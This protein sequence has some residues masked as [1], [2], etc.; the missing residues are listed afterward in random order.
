MISQPGKQLLPNISSRQNCKNHIILKL[1]PN[2][3]LTKHWN[4]KQEI[5]YYDIVLAGNGAQVTIKV[6][7][8]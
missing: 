8:H 1:S 5:V 7:C 6:S 3:F 4:W 2:N